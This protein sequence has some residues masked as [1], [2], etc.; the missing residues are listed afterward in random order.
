MDRC[1]WRELILDDNFLKHHGLNYIINLIKNSNN[2]KLK[3]LSVRNNRVVDGSIFYL[4]SNI[5]NLG[6]E[7][8]DLS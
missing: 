3:V 6:I 5:E 8:L 2:N 1:A 7:K 4:I